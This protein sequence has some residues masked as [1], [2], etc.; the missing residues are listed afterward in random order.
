MNDNITIGFIG[1]GNMGG[2]IGRGVLKKAAANVV[3]LD[4]P[5]LHRHLSVEGSSQPTVMAPADFFKTVRIIFLG[6]KPAT[7]DAVSG[8]YRDYI[9]PHHVIVSMMAGIPLVRLASAFNTPHII[10]MMPNTP[11]ALGV[12]VTGLYFAPSITPETRTMVVTL[13]DAIGRTVD[14]Q[15]EDDLHIITALSGSGPAFF[16]RIV[17]AFSRFASEHGLDSETALMA[18][19]N[20]MM[21]AGAMLRETPDPMALVAQVASPNGTTQAGLLAMDEL[22]LDVQLKAVLSAAHKRS[23]EL[24]K[25]VN[26]T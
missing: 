11:A 6:T 1:Y 24:S 8:A 3:V 22:T 21:G 17:H 5:S 20:T 16:Y 10:R 25:G 13:C 2:A 19:T 18:V 14:V 9:Q 4:H 26:N 7:L 23:I 12:G 15:K